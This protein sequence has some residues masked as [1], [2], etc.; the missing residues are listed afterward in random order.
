MAFNKDFHR[1]R[2]ARIMEVYNSVKE[3]DIPDTF[4]LR[5]IFPKHG[6]YISRRTFI[7]YKGMKPS[8][9]LPLKAV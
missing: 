8:E 2:V 3:Q 6:I 1:Q 5:N 4:I 7:N 9:Y